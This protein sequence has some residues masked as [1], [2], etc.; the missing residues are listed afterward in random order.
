VI[1]LPHGE[2]KMRIYVVLCTVAWLILFP[3]LPSEAA[4][5]GFGKKED[6]PVGESHQTE[7]VVQYVKYGVWFYSREEDLGKEARDVDRANRKLM[8]VGSRITTLEQ[9]EREGVLY[10]RVRLPDK[11]EYWVQSEALVDRFIVINVP[12]VLCYKQPDDTFADTVFLQ[13]G[14]MGY[15]IEQ[16]EGWIKA[17]FL[18]Y[19]PRE[20]EGERLWV[21]ERWIKDYGYTGDIMAAKE[22]Y[23]LFL[24]NREL[25]TRDN[26]TKAAEFLE[27]GLNVNVVGDTE[28]TSVLRD[29][30]RK[31]SGPASSEESPSLESGGDVPSG[32][33]DGESPGENSPEEKASGKENL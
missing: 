2:E 23:Y 5:L 32:S 20:P 21:G 4:K 13:P 11:S 18:A 25:I 26:P 17:N 12:D 9:K 15:F 8:D 19:R 6:R 33:S 16:Q 22:A 14:D 24:A 7:E 29:L 3:F 1:G 10:S 27:T 30:L 31:I 28:I